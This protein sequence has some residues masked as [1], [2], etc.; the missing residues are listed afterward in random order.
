MNCVFEDNTALQGGAI[1][2][3]SS[4]AATS[5]IITDCHFES[6][7]T[8]NA[9]SEA[10]SGGAIKAWGPSD[11]AVDL[12]ITDCT[13]DENY[14]GGASHGGGAIHQDAPKGTVTV[15][16]CSFDRNASRGAGGAIDCGRGSLLELNNST[17]DA[18]SAEVTGGAIRAYGGS[19]VEADSCLFESCNADSGGA[20]ACI[21]ECD[22]VNS[23]T[24]CT[25]DANTGIQG[26]AFFCA[27]D[28]STYL[29]N[30]TFN[31]NGGG[32]IGGNIMCRD[33]AHVDIEE[34]I[35]AFGS[36]GGSAWCLTGGTIDVDC[37]D[38][39]GNTGGNWGGCLASQ[40]NGSGLNDNISADPLFCEDEG[41]EYWELHSD[42]PCCADSSLCGNLMGAW[43]VGCGS[44]ERA[45]PPGLEIVGDAS[46]REKPVAVLN[47]FR[48]TGSIV[49][50]VPT[51]ETSSPVR[52]AIYDIAGRLVRTLVDGRVAPG[53]HNAT[54]D[55]CDNAGRRVRPGMYFC[56]SHIG[57]NVA[58]TRI[59]LLR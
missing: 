19:R 26:G 17:F 45:I 29:E 11:Y 18:D 47:P 1:W 22:G 3:L 55:G 44:S 34:T 23:F 9:L 27:R 39:Y 21:D 49:Y 31:D 41:D 54:W 20:V 59:V 25:C 6:N 56:R 37:T 38:I 33:S 58:A 50:Q 24:Y 7:A 15:S 35:I 52:L 28:D 53:S 4:S 42:S 48:G 43:D 57:S 46:G 40:Y 13:F 32:L 12:T 36:G 8:L 5:V 10:Y 16:G 30:C 2:A 51:G 14:S